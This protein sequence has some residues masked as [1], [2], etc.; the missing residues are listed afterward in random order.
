[1]RRENSSTGLRIQQLQL[2]RQHAT[3]GLPDEYDQEDK[4]RRLKSFSSL[5]SIN[6]F[7]SEQ[8]SSECTR[9]LFSDVALGA[10]CFPRHEFMN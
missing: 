1:M 2:A 3:Y 6:F 7:T 10:E 9:A 5:L 8:Q 4:R